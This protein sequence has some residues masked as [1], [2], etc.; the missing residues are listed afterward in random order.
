MSARAYNNARKARSCFSFLLHL[1]SIDTV[2]N[3]GG[4]VLSFYWLD[5]GRYKGQP[6]QW[7]KS[8]RR[9]CLHASHKRLPHLTN[10]TTHCLSA[11]FCQLLIT[12]LGSST[13][14]TVA[15]SFEQ[16]F[17]R[18]C[19]VPDTQS[20]SFSKDSKSTGLGGNH[21]SAAR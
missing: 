21:W 10:H 14:S 8:Q 9:P 16:N 7:E 3:N 4:N 6:S 15:R 19:T 17:Q 20:Q 12:P 18:Q 2:T 5:G 11:R 1:A 13:S